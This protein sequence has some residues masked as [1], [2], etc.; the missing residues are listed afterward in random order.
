MSGIDYV[1]WLDELSE[2]GRAIQDATGYGIEALNVAQYRG[3]TVAVEN[4]IVELLN[5]EHV[6]Y[7]RFVEVTETN[8]MPHHLH[9]AAGLQVLKSLRDDLTNGRLVSLRHLVT[10]E[11]FSDFLDM[12]EHLIANGYKDA[13][14]SLVGAVLERGLRDLASANELTLRNR[15]DLT[16]LA[17]RLAEKDVYSRLV[18][19]QLTVWISVRNSADH[20]KFNEYTLSDVQDMFRGVA[21]FLAQY[22]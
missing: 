10:A 22:V 8:V 12:A 1:A 4:F 2:K 6:Y 11:V 20:G 15:D 9:R 17:N 19:K 14:A 13:G 5:P 7:L 18:Q 16:A 21:G 3:W